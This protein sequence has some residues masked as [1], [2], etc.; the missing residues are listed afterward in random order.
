MHIPTNTDENVAGGEDLSARI[1]A[2][3]HNR[4]DR[5]SQHITR[6]EV[7][8][9]D[10][11]G[12]KSGAADQR[13]LTEARLEGP[14]PEAA[15]GRAGILEGAYSGAAKKVHRASETTLGRLNHVKGADTIPDRRPV[16]ECLPPDNP[17]NEPR[18]NQLMVEKQ[19]KTPAPQ[20]SSKSKHDQGKGEDNAA[21]RSPEPGAVDRGGFDLGGSTG[22]THAGTGLGPGTDAADTRRDRRLPGRRG[23][24]T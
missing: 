9:S 19:P 24:S 23:K 17:I 14:Q 1:S 6:I 12:D 8:L 2:E 18:R 5:F 4:F 3:L 11:D 20:T 13:C 7:H 15:S 21:D 10:E 16:A 22:K